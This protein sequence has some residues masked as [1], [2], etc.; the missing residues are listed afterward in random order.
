MTRRRLRHTLMR[1][2]LLREEAKVEEKMISSEGLGIHRWVRWIESARN[3][4]S[5]TAIGV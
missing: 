1:V 5:L 2:R 4:D 3:K